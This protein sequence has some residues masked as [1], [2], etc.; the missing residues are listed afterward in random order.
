MNIEQI[1][2]LSDEEAKSEFIRCCGSE[3]WADKMLGG[4]PYMGE[5]E[6]LHFSEKKW[7]HL[8]EQDWLEAF[9]HH[10]K[11]GDIDS[12]SKKYSDTKQWAEGEQS[13]VN[14][15]TQDII[16]NLADGNQAYE[17]KFGYIFIVCAT[18]KT[19]Q[20]MLDILNKRLSN[21]PDEEIKIAMKEQNKITRI[22]LEKLL[23]L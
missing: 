6:L 13:G 21:L 19:A 22:R 4:R 10:P 23:N 2:N 3:A 16:K 8:S 11:I 17:D 9:K 7:F 1:N 15:A 12:L 20:E 5:D 14:T 18:G